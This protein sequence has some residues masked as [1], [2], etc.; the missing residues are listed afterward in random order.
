MNQ[1][2]ALVVVVPRWPPLHLSVC[3]VLLSM[4]VT[5][6]QAASWAGQSSKRAHIESIGVQQIVYE[7]TH[8]FGKHLRNIHEASALLWVE[9][10]CCRKSAFLERGG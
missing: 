3:W 2:W 7:S 4:L 6:L 1:Q 5:S 10:C 9:V 8:A